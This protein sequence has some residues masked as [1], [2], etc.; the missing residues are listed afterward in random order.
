MMTPRDFWLAL[1]EHKGPG[2]LLLV[3]L[4]SWKRVADASGMDAVDILTSVFTG[5]CNTATTTAML[6]SL[7]STTVYAAYWGPLGSEAR[8]IQ[9]LDRWLPMTIHAAD[10]AI[11]VRDVRVSVARRLGESGRSCYRSGQGS[12]ETALTSVPE[13]ERYPALSVTWEEASGL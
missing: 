12:I 1:D 3:V 9:W 2:T 13:N 5:L 7:V 4:T 6:R 11:P 8:S 10:L